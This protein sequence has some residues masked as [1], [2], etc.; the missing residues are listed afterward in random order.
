MDGGGWTAPVT[1]K[2]RY[3][4]THETCWSVVG[5]VGLAASPSSIETR[6]TLSQPVALRLS[7]ATNPTRRQGA[8][9]RAA[10]SKYKNGPRGVA[11]GPENRIYW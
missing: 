4:T 10:N 1:D 8:S 11:P 9:R 2:T 6:C 3:I 7:H 5:D